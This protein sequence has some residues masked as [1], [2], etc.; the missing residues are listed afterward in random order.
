M[1]PALKEEGVLEWSYL[2]SRCLPIAWNKNFH[3]FQLVYWKKKSIIFWCWRG[4]VLVKESGKVLQ[5]PDLLVQ[6]KNDLK[7]SPVRGYWRTWA[8]LRYSIC[9]NI[10]FSLWKIMTYCKQC[11]HVKM[12]LCVCIYQYILYIRLLIPFLFFVHTVLLYQAFLFK[13]SRFK[14]SSDNWAVQWCLEHVGSL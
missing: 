13:N 1:K 8:F 7:I 5:D 4:R 2:K 9:S 10:F 3:T 12:K 11:I 6:Q 14:L